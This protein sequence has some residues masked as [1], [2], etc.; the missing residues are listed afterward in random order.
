MRWGGGAILGRY[1]AHVAAFV[2]LPQ[3]RQG[4]YPAQPANNVI[5]RYVFDNL[6]RLNVVPSPLSTDAE[7]LRRVTLDTLG[8]LPTPDEIKAFTSST[9]RTSAQSSSTT[10]SSGLN[11]PITAPSACLTCCAEPSQDQQYRGPWRSRG[12]PFL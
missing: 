11:S 6:K 9:A 5:D 12:H 10:C 4:P 2:T 1:L 8:R 3:A 7:F